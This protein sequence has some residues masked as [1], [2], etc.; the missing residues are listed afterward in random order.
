[1]TTFHMESIMTLTEAIKAHGAVAS[2]QLNHVGAQN[3]PDAIPGHKN[4]IGLLLLFVK[5]AFRLKK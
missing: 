3:H 1:M 5:T 4:P 2:I